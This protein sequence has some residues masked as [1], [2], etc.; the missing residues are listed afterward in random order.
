VSYP[1][2]YDMPKVAIEGASEVAVQASCKK[3]VE[4]EFQAMF[5][6]VPNG[7]KRGF[8]AQQQVKKEGLTK[9]FPD[10]IIVG[11]GKNAGKVA[12]AEIKAR[13]SMSLEQQAMLEHLVRHNHQAGLFRSQDTIA[14]KLREWGWM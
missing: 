2:H 9:G 6:A 1:F 11:Y 12:F 4:A 14:A 7:G 3:R 5:V 10:A 13:G 8:M